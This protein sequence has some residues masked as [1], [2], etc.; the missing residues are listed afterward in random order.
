MA[1]NTRINPDTFYVNGV[2]I[3]A[4]YFQAVDTAQFKAL[5]GDAGGAWNPSGA[6]AISGAGI[7]FCGPT[8]T[9]TGVGISSGIGGVAGSQCVFAD[10]D[11]P[12][13][14]AGHAMASRSIL[15]APGATWGDASGVPAARGSSPGWSS[16]GF[17]NGDLM[18]GGA[19]SRV[20]I[21]LEVHNF[22]TLA[23]VT[24]T[25]VPSSA[26]VALPTVFPAMRVYATDVNGTVFPI[27]GSTLPGATGF[28]SLATPA[29]L[30]AYAGVTQAIIYTIF[31]N[32]TVLR[33][34]YTYML[35]IQDEAGAG[36]IGGNR[37]KQIQ[38]VLTG[39][40]GLYFP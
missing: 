8:T 37:Y 10:N 19:G 24:L 33:G 25:F 13:L 40:P 4:T 7:W 26:H 30:G 31:A 38:T 6:I 3:P 28:V 35:E 32:T 18:G 29:N 22:A 12:V 39:I 11:V 20:L 23:Q 5:N 27:G 16:S 34:T 15:Q 1:H 14:T 9:V 21:P 2:A 36:S 17:A